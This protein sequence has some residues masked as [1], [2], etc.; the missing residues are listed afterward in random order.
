VKTTHPA[1]TTAQAIY[2]RPG[3]LEP[4]E[5]TFLAAVHQIRGDCSRTK[6]Q[7]VFMFGSGSRAALASHNLSDRQE[8]HDMDK[9]MAIYQEALE[10]V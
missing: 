4:Y 6:G 9:A 8:G 7:A 3:D 1:I 2:D 5:Q 10:E